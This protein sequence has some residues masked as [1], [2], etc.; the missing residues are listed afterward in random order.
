MLQVPYLKRSSFL[1]ESCIFTTEGFSG[2]PT[3]GKRSAE[4]KREKSEGAL[5][6][7]IDFSFATPARLL[8]KAIEM[9]FAGPNRL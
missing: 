8:H 5:R 2:S 4:G 6:A 9:T 3:F 7:F 1:T